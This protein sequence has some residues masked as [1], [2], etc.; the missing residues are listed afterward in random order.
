MDL[1]KGF[2]QE[3][4]EAKENNTV[5]FTEASIQKSVSTSPLKPGGSNFKTHTLVES[6]TSQLRYRPSV[7]GTLF[8]FTFFAIGFGFI[9]YNMSFDNGLIHNPSLSN[10]FG[11]AFGLIFA[12]I[13]G[14]ILYNLYQPRVFDKQS[15]YYYKGYNFKPNERE[16][17]HQFKLN[18]IIA[19]QIIG[20]TISNSDGSYGSYELNLVLEDSTRRN[21][22]DHGSLK[23]IIDD[24]YVVSAFLNVPIWHA[25]TPKS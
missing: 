20:E 25:E 18:S 10:L 17:K 5:D 12:F 21:V 3:V 15:G 6:S 14:Y 4:I 8:G 7:G 11:L 23:A 19:V 13:G 16:L 22:V 24:A 9:I 1:P 2:H